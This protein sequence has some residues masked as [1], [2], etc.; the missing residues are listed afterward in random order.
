MS[1]LKPDLFL[2]NL[3]IGND[4]IGGITCHLDLGISPTNKMAQGRAEVF[5]ATNPV[6]YVQSIVTGPYFYMCTMEDCHIRIDLIGYEDSENGSQKNFEATIVLTED[7]K[8]GTANYSFS[9]NGDWTSL[10]DQK[11]QLAENSGILDH[12]KLADTVKLAEA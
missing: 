7:W 8:T 2:L 1:N 9:N 11:V 5:Q 12:G 10:S 6:L 3:R 4:L